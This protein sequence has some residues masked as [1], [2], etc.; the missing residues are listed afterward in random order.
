MKTILVLLILT[1]STTL[2]YCQGD[3]DIKKKKECY[4]KKEASKDNRFGE[5]ECGKLAGVVDCNEKLTYDENTK[6]ILSGNSGSPFS[7]TCETCHMNGKLERR[8]TFVNGK[9]NGVDT[10]YYKTGCVQV[11]RNH[12]QGAESGQWQYLYDST[13]NLA[14]ERNYNLGQLHGR[15]LYMTKDKD[16]TR[17]EHYNNGLLHGVKKSY[18]PKSKIEKEINYVNGLIDGSFKSYSMDGKLIQ[19]L[20]YKQGKKNGELKYYYDDG[21]LMSTEH[22]T[23]DVKDGEFKT[24]YYEGKLQSMENYKKGVAEGWFEERWPD[25]N[26]KRRA[27]YKKGV[28]IEEHRYDEHGVEN[29]TFGVETA[30][31]NEDDAMPGKKKK[32]RKKGEE[33]KGGLI[34][35]E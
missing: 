34:K 4:E 18:Y 8:I 21:V 20:T 5:W 9:E 1:G 29:Y 12:I 23:M 24:F 17:L 11:I 7:G 30:S 15:Q 31:G 13:Q 10:T 6:L 33:T 2:A 28:V 19:D 16:T 32:K 14:W 27:L 26:L 35:M 3:F 22:W 25:D